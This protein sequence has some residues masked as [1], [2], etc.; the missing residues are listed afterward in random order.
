[1]VGEREEALTG[2]PRSCGIVER[3]SWTGGEEDG[4]ERKGEWVGVDTR[5]GLHN[6]DGSGLR[7]GPTG[8]PTW[9]ISLQLYTRMD[10]RGK[11]VIT[12]E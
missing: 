5:G 8:R 1:M 6:D 12:R 2:A 3:W 10:V 7:R 11:N 4:E 9:N